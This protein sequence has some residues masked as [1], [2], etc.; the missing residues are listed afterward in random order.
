MKRKF[1]LMLMVVLAFANTGCKKYLEVQPSGSY[2][3]IQVFTNPTAIQQALN[4]LYISLADNTLY[5]AAL[6]QTYLELMAQQFRG[7]MNGINFY[8]QFQQNNYQEL[9]AKAKFDEMWT[10]AYN[11]ILAA[12][13]FYEKVNGSIKS[14]VISEAEGRIAKGEAT[15][16]RA[17]LHF[18]LLRIFGPVYSLAPNQPAI[19]YYRLAN[20]KTQPFST[21]EQIV[22]LIMEDLD[23]ATAYLQDDAIRKSGTAMS[24]NFYTSR[25]NHRLNYY[26]VQALKAR[27]FLWAGKNSEAH[28]AALSVLTEGEQW[29]PWLPYTAI[30]GTNTPD[31]IF[32]V[33][34]IF[35]L[36]NRSLYNNHAN[37]F[38]ASQ[39]EGY[40]LAPAT[41]NLL[42]TFENNENDYR[43]VSSW[44]QTT[45][46]FRTFFKFEEGVSFVDPRAFIQPMIRKS[47]LYYILAETEADPVRAVGYLNAVRNNRGLQNLNSN[48]PLTIEISKEYRKEFYGEGQ[49]FFYYKRTN[50][51]SVAD[52]MTNSP[53]V[54]EYAVP[55]P[56][57]E[58]TP[59]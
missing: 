31:R 51:P 17:L 41:V 49:L 15:A 52:A 36:Y 56:L 1:I 8:E 59:R 40:L 29:F 20:A 14:G 33:E 10:M 23:A 22:T 45:K 21:S 16:I 13:L 38:S 35:G 42:N 18:D 24:D 7:V 44:R 3:E 54:L 9:G 11:T 34:V 50:T 37:F 25:R 43:Y 6:T 4:G 47:E 53:K 46:A 39:L 26:A 2:T 5:G 58:I 28:A 55:L 32:S 30:I 12:N 48:A 57:S 27:V 19:P